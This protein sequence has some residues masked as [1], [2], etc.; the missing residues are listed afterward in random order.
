MR[1]FTFWTLVLLSSCSTK[2]EVTQENKESSD[3]IT[4]IQEGL[5]QAETKINE[6][7]RIDFSLD[8]LLKFDSETELKNVFGDKINTNVASHRVGTN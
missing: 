3:T 8:S 6:I 2:K 1:R 5:P 7:I 4:T